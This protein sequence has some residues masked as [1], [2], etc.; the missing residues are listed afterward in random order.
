MPSVVELDAMGSLAFAELAVVIAVF[1]C[2]VLGTYALLAARMRRFFGSPRAMRLVNRGSRGGSRS[3]GGLRADQSSSSRQP[4]SSTARMMHSK[5][6]HQTTGGR[7]MSDRM[8]G[9]MIR[10]KTARR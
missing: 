2:G 7:S 3:R 1:I 10:N 6:L 5:L 9:T 8:M 4:R